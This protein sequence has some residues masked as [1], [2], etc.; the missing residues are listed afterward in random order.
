MRRLLGLR[1]LVH[2]AIDEI[3]NLVEATHEGVARKPVALLSRVEPLGGVAREVDAVRRGVARLAFDGVRQTNRSV[4]A[5]CDRGIR[6]AAEVAR[7]RGVLG[8]DQPVSRPLDGAG[9][10]PHA[11][12]GWVERAESALNGAVGDF[13]EARG[14]PLATGMWLRHGGR[15]LVLGRAE[16][17]AALPHASG[18]LIVFVHGLASSD[19]VWAPSAPSSQRHD[20][21]GVSVG[22]P[23]SV[24]E[25]VS[26]GDEVAR[27]LGYTPLYLRYN[28]GLPISKNGRALARLLTELVAAYPLHIESLALVGHSMGGLVVQS[29]AQHAADLGEP[30]L[31]RLDHVLGIG[32]PHFGAPLA[33]AAHVVSS[34]AALFDTAG[35]QVPAKVLRARSAGMKDLSLG[36]LLDAHAGDERAGAGRAK[37]A[38]ASLFAA[39]GL[40]FVEGVA[41][42]YIAARSR[43]S[44]SRASEWIGDWLVHLPSASGC[45]PN[46]T[47]HIPFHMGHVV[48]GVHHVALTTHP[49]V[50]RQLERF[51]TECRAPKARASEGGVPE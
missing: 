41:Y 4:Q 22:Q 18:K 37:E 3:T 51:L 11:V 43:P 7:A 19:S 1:D 33:R 16:L 5:L 40:R 50:C 45:H 28:S 10:L 27:A 35:T 12:E 8:G 38:E 47:R 24:G 44:G 46:A 17:G 29:A 48:D 39:Q 14:N 23:V 13:L 30:W 9:A 20:G 15:P 36:A 34:L 26:F 42:G 6:L 31:A 25:P 32:T 21:T 2:D 49:D